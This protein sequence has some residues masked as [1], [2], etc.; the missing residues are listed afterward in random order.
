MAAQIQRLE[1]EKGYLQEIVDALRPSGH[2]LQIGFNAGFAADHIQT[3]YPQQHTII[4]SDPLRADQASTW[5]KKYANVTVIKGT[6]QENLANLS[7]FDAILFDDYSDGMDTRVLHAAR[8]SESQLVNFVMSTLPHLENI[9]YT[10]ED[11]CNFLDENA[12]E[13]PLQIAHFLSELQQREQISSDQYAY[14]MREYCLEPI[15][16][17]KIQTLIYAQDNCS[18]FL[19]TCLKNHLNR[20]GRFSCFASNPLSRYA[21][22]W[23]FENVITNLDL[24]YQ[25]RWIEV[26]P[27]KSCI[28]YPY[29]TALIL[30]IENRKPSCT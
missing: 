19:E 29:D 23:F 22:P 12:E 24:D 28:Y 11:L 6:W 14:M 9:H 21:D 3:F 16:S 7:T 25:E 15:K 4:E 26:A 27:P 18:L 20:G 8:H 1:W 30:T 17:Q 5:A 13:M 10:N 2:V